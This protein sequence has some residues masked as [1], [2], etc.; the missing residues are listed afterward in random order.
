MKHILENSFDRPG[1]LTSEVTAPADVNARV[2]GNR[3]VFT[4]HA[5]VRSRFN[6]QDFSDFYQLI[7]GLR[8]ASGALAGDR[9]KNGAAG[10]QNEAG[11]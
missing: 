3:T 4:D 8:E 11:R 6:G 1:Q 10:R 5:M 7:R 2:Y 9:V